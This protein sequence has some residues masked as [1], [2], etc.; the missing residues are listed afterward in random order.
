MPLSDSDRQTIAAFRQPFTAKYA[1]DAR[2]QGV[3]TDDRSDDALL[4]SRFQV[5][6]HLWLE[7][8]VRPFIPQVRVGIVTDDRWKNEDLEDKIEESGDSMSEFIEMGFEE[9]GLEW[10]DPPVEHF[11]EQG[12]FFCFTTAVELD[13]LSRLSEPATQRKLEQMFDGY[14]EA[15]KHAILKAATAPE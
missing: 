3:H 14:Y 13:K 6:E 15:F 1:G 12:K 8:A 11:R 9:A 2:F 5:A 10:I 7:L 4:A